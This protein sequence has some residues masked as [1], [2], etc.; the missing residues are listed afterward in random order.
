MYAGTSSVGEEEEVKIGWPNCKI[1]GFQK[2]SK[3][4][5]DGMLRWGFSNPGYPIVASSSPTK[6]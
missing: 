2:G 3:W 1:C 6:H 5:I 4:M